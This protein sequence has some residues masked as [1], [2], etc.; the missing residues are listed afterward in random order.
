MNGIVDQNGMRPV[1]DGI[2]L[3]AEARALNSFQCF[4]SVGWLTGGQW[5]HQTTKLGSAIEGQHC[6]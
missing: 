1:G 2:S 3:L 4:D 6:V 5:H